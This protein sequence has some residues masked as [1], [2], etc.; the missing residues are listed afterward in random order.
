MNAADQKNEEGIVVRAIVAN[1]HDVMDGEWGDREWLHLF[2]DFEV[3]ATGERTSAICFA[4]ARHGNDP[5]EK[6]AFRLPF[7]ARQILAAVAND[8]AARDGKRWTAARIRVEQDGGYSIDY[9][10]DAPYRLG[11]T[12][13]DKRYADYLE[14]WLDSDQG[15]RYRAPAHS[16]LRK[17]FGGKGQ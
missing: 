9:V 14:R 4:L 3:D 10:Y 17:W 16:T 8:M 6:I 13:N 11:G 12:L 7:E 2:A 1:V 5:V 15:A